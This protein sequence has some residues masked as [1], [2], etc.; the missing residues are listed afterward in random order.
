VVRRMYGSSRDET[1]RWSR[2]RTAGRRWPLLDLRMPGMDG[3]ALAA[4][5]ERHPVPKYPDHHRDHAEPESSE[6]LAVAAVGVPGW[7]GS[8][9]Q[10]RDVTGMAESS[11]RPI[12]IEPTQEKAVGESPRPWMGD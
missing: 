7:Y 3:V 8:V 2:W 9:H 6:L 10:V 1:M 11:R 12:H 5:F 4:R